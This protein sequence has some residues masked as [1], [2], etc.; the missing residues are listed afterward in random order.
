M[1]QFLLNGQSPIES[2]VRSCDSFTP[3]RREGFSRSSHFTGYDG[4]TVG[5]TLVIVES[6]AKAQTISRFLGSSYQVEASF[7]HV[8][9]LPNNADEI[10]EDIRGKSWARLGVDVENSYQPVYVVPPDKKRHVT[11]LRKA[12]KNADHLLLATDEDREGESIVWHLLEVLRPKIPVQRI[13][14]HEVTPEAIKE[15]LANPRDVDERLVRA[16]ES[17]RVLDRLYGYTLSPLLWKKVQGGLSAGRVQSVAV[18]LCVMREQERAA[19]H[20]SSYWDI[21]ATLNAQ[22][23]TFQATLTRL[24]DKRMPAGKDFDPS[25]GQLKAEGVHILDRA[26]AEKLCS[27]L[28]NAAPWTVTKLQ[29]TPATSRPAP[30][31]ITSTLQQEANRKLGF[32]AR[33]TMSAAQELYEGI[34]LRGG[35]RVGLITY[36]RTDSVTLAERAIEEARQLIAK[37]YGADYI[38]AQPRRYKTKSKNAQE[39]HEAIRPTELHRDPQSVRASLTPDQY[40]LYELI[41]KRTLACQMADAQLQRTTL[42]V[43]VKS[44]GD[45]AVFTAR[46]KKILFPGY[47]RAYVEGSDDP[48]AEIGDQE[49][50]IPHIDEGHEVSADKL[51]AKGHETQP[52]ARYTEAS[53]IRKLEEEGIGRPSTY[54]SIITTI[55]LRGYV[56]KLGNALVPTFTA[57]AVTHLLEKHF[58]DLVDLQFTARMEDALDDI[59]NGRL[60]WLAHIDDF[61]RGG[62]QNPGLEQRVEKEVDLIQYPAIPVRGDGDTETASE[63]PIVVRIGRFGPYLQQ[64]ENNG[65]AHRASIP[66]DFPPADLD[67]DKARELLNAKKEGPRVVGHDPETGQEISVRTGRFGPYIQLGHDRGDADPKDYKPKRASLEHGMSEEQVTLEEALRLLSLPRF[68]GKH[69]DSGIDIFADRGRY[70]PYVRMEKEYRSLEATDDVYTVELDRALEL[71]AQPKGRRKAAVKTVLK[72]LG[73]AP[74]SDTAI[75]VMDG[76][77]GPYVTDGEVNATL[78]RGKKPDEV[79]LDEGLQLLAEKRAKGPGR[80]KQAATTKKTATKKKTTA[81]KKTTTKKKSTAKKTTSKRKTAAKKKSAS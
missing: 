57:Y 25:T 79:T 44:D 32:T 41:W 11:N 10:P 34:S 39:A 3:G 66:Q 65:D 4:L 43:S 50:I 29:E 67:Y 80:R 46:G 55:Q 47:L 14:F 70:G 19:F 38:P 7:G 13:V 75:K 73:N 58:G 18:R 42:D 33:R 51:D 76:R 53:L 26:A 31:F 12:L 71:L 48:M 22:E 63:P 24:N 35:E 21:E 60:D 30:P 49:S 40:K 45:T 69:P 37:R 28:K 62:T 56:F 64:G 52:P 68:L 23:G 36:M 5:K 15:A 2:I 61:Y 74:D 16:Q 72:E 20:S 6:P 9:D 77:Y 1:C 59:S 78:P 81:K 8:R 17:R 54:A 27:N